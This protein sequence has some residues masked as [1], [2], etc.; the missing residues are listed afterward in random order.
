MK[1]LKFLNK[2]FYRYIWYLLGGIF[3]VLLSNVFAIVPAQVVRHAFDLVSE[4]IGLH[5]LYDGMQAGAEIDDMLAFS[6]LLYGGLIV[7]MALIRGVFLFFMRQTI[8]VMSRKIEYRLKSDIYKKY[9]SLPMSFY[10]KHNTGDLMARI[11]EDVGHVRMYV[12]PGIMY[13]INMIGTFV[14]VV[15]YML[16]VNVK[17]T[18]YSV[19]PLPILSLSIYWVH[20]HMNQR[21][22][23]IQKSLSAITTYVQEAFSGIRVIKAFVK[24]TDVARK[25]EHASENYMNKSMGL[26]QV[27]SMF[28]P[29]IMGLISLSSI[30]T[31][32]V[33]GLEVMNGSITAGNIAEFLIYVTMLTWPVTSLGW[34]TSIVQRAIVSQQRI[35]EFMKLESDIVSTKHLEKPIKGHIQFKNVS[36]VYPE[37]GIKALE[38]VSFEIEDGK[39]LAI[40]G[41]TGSGKSTLANLICRAY[42][43]TEGQIL[44]DESP[45]PEYNITYLRSK[46]GYVPQDV[47]LFS[48]TIRNNIAFGFNEGEYSEE[49]VI[50]AAKDADL[51]NNITSFEKGFDTVVGERGITLSGGQKQR[52]SIARAIIRSPKILLLDDCL[53]AVDTKT[54]NVILT[55]LK[56]FMLNKTSVIISH[57]V[58]SAKI[59]DK[60]VVLDGGRVVEQGTHEELMSLNGMYQE[61]YEKQLQTESAAD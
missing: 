54:E 60:I 21:S 47:F 8:I 22:S 14:M 3:F 1:E 13:F 23:D 24:E 9:Q 41:T 5:R 38:E 55:N 32:Y 16:T 18:L 56:R 40:L 57:R 25:F 43:P 4:S 2:Y 52:I 7:L 6:V 17:L 51:L 36:F 48:E 29:L 27:N 44:I 10:R 19:L 49:D 61:L 28:T 34:T 20:N 33:G 59:A 37:S 35:N 11:S 30:I 12:G 45:L 26:I 39:I 31:V 42:D 58:S 50:Q 53:S 46:I 15:A